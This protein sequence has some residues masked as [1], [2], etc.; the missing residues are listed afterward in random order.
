[1]DTPT[2]ALH[3]TEGLNKDTRTIQGLW[4]A[5]LGETTHLKLATK[6]VACL[7]RDH[8]DE[9]QAADAD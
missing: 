6:G 3:N 8:R 4:K 1:M 2:E 9:L 7:F 5:Y